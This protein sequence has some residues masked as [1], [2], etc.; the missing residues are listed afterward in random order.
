LQILKA[1]KT[2]KALKILDFKAFINLFKYVFLHMKKVVAH[3]FSICY[4]Q[5]CK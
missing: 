3:F 4:N 5:N 1:I 2:Y